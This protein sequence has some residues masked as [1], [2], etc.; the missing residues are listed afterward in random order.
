[1]NYYEYL[2]RGTVEKILISQNS[3]IFMSVTAQT[4]RDAMLAQASELP[5]DQ[6]DVSNWYLMEH[7]AIWPYFERTSQRRSCALP[8]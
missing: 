6:L 3:G 5:L 7:D 8:Q 1:M 4:P 2:V